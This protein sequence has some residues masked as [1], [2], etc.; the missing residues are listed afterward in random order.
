MPKD[1]VRQILLGWVVPPL[2]L[3]R[4]ITL[5]THWLAVQATEAGGHEKHARLGKTVQEALV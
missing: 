1:C 2:H 3:S 5:Q 4:L